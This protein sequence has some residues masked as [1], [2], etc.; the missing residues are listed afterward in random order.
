M[1][2]LLLYCSDY[3]VAR[4]GKNRKEFPPLGV[5]YLAAACE[6]EGINVSVKDLATIGIGEIPSFNIIGISINTSYI[7]PSFKHRI[8][9]IKA[10]CRLIFVGGQHASIYPYETLTEL[11]AD[12][13]M[14]GEGEFTL[15]ALI[16]ECYKNAFSK[17]IDYIENAYCVT[18]IDKAAYSETSRIKNLDLIPFPARHLLPKEDILLQKRIPSYDILSTTVITSR[19]CPYGCQ[20]CGNL[21]K[22]FSFRSAENVRK[23]IDNI[24]MQ[25]QE[26]QGIVF[27]DEN[28]FFNKN[29]ALEIIDCMKS[30]KLKWTC[31][32]RVDGFTQEILPYAKDSGCVEIKYGIESGSQ[33]ILDLMN[34]R[35]SIQIMERTLKETIRNGIR[36][37]CFLM[38]GFPG[39]DEDSAKATIAFLNRNKK[40]IN[41]VNL[42]SFTPVPNSPIYNRKICKEYSWEDYKIYYQLR[43]WWGSG[44]QY[45]SIINGYNLLKKYVNENYG[46]N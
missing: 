24:K 22:G 10:K 14:I 6:K 5:L 3:N 4:F 1:E 15:P 26:I 21:Y 7:Y 37:K 38:Y 23:E 42:F 44:K 40:N 41:R 32:A 35:V 2:I 8:D 13:L 33:K 25:Y 17:D 20:F 31:N 18:N 36:T 19:G 34:K 16:N 12:Y 27:L 29:H 30:L 43:H 46:E 39:D 11:N 28:L 9:E 45:K